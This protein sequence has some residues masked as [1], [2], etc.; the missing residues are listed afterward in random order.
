MQDDTYPLFLTAVK[1]L[2]SL[3][4]PGRKNTQINLAQAMG[5]DKVSLNAA[6]NRRIDTVSG[7]EMRFSEAAQQA[8]AEYYGMTI[9]ALVQIGGRLQAGET[10]NYQL[11]ELRGGKVIAVNQD[12][13]RMPEGQRPFITGRPL[14]N[15]YPQDKKLTAFLPAQV[16]KCLK[17]EAAR[18]DV[19]MVQI[20]VE[21]L[22]RELRE[23]DKDGLYQELDSL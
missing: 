4:L 13:P 6:M 9:D 14:V 15:P 8:I 20:V 17:V 2:L 5:R 22:I 1:Y 11:H 18:R 23:N 7:Q 19:P 12:A 21:A 10:L 3:K 16:H